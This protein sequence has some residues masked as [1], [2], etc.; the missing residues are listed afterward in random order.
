MRAIRATLIQ[1]ISELQAALH[2]HL[3]SAL[4]QFGKEGVTYEDALEWILSEELELI[5]GL[6]DERHQGRR[7]HR[8][9]GEIYQIVRAAVEIPLSTLVSHLV[10]APIL[11]DNNLIQLRVLAMDLYIVYSR[12]PYYLPEVRNYSSIIRIR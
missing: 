3:N 10:S 6:F 4:E 12:D 2:P 8:V 9:Y 7:G 1:S 11:Y 5:Y